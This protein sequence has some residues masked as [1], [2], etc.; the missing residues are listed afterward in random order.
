M[1]YLAI[2]DK[3]FKISLP[4]KKKRKKRKEK[5]RIVNGSHK[6]ASMRSIITF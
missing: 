5:R 2:N 3:Q 4:K 6:K 1:E